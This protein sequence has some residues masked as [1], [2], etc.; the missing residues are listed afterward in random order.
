VTIE[1]PNFTTSTMAAIAWIA[2]IP[3]FSPCMVGKQVP[4]DASK[5]G[6][7]AP[8]VAAKLGFV[9]VAVVGGSPDAMLPIKRPVIEARCWDVVPG[10]SLPPWNMA[11]A[12]AEAI[13]YAALDEIGCARRLDISQ[14]GVAYPPAQVQAAK[15]LTE[16]REIYND[17]GDYAGMSLDV[18]MQW[19]TLTDVLA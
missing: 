15:A 4:P 11:S 19:I 1:I 8:W 13:R 7:P 3:G 2:T 16:P 10:S 5:D 12:L 14:N 17:A 6:T 18:W 9:Q